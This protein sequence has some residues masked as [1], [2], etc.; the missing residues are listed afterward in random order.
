[1]FDNAI[2]ENCEVTAWCK[3]SE[4]ITLKNIPFGM[5]AFT[6][7]ED[8]T[9]SRNIWPHEHMGVVYFGI[10]G[11]SYDDAYYDRK[12][13]ESDTY[14]KSGLLYQ[15]LRHH[16]TELGRE[17]KL[18]A[19]TSSHTKFF[20]EFGFAENHL[21]KINVCVLTPK[22][23]L[24]NINVRSWLY[25]IESA[26]I[27]QYSENFGYQPLMQIAHSAD[28]S[29]ALIDENTLNQKKIREVRNNNLQE[30]FSG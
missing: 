20:E 10:A 11:K 7:P 6:G 17:P 13:K 14:H 21:S 3:M 9:P 22:K 4:I 5:Y 1:M 16:R 27:Y 30:F 15:R 19:K 29:A 24:D 8:R 25:A 18:F 23:K 2:K 12:V 26:S 28:C